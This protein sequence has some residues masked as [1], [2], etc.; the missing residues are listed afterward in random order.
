[1]FK[2]FVNCMAVAA[3]VVVGAHPASAEFVN[4]VER[5]NGT[6][7]DLVTWEAYR[8]STFSQNDALIIT[9]P[10]L[11]ISDYTTR[12]VTV[13]VGDTV[14][15]KVRLDDF[16]TSGGSVFG[17]V[18]LLLTDNSAGDTG[19]FFSDNEHSGIRLGLSTISGP[20]ISVNNGPSGQ[21][22]HQFSSPILGETFILELE[23][24]DAN[25]VRYAGYELDGTLIAEIT[26]VADLPDQAFVG[27]ASNGT[28]WFDDVSVPEPAS[29]TLLC[30]LMLAASRRRRRG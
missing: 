17:F 25:N 21:R 14:S 8:P 20:E 15:A 28:A 13:G 7:L 30:G 4:E 26:R 18:S 27:L 16:S 9:N 1:M 10:G 11:Q 22:I 23:R 12:N 3:G 5:F 6:T 29:A 2:R 19:S 24:V